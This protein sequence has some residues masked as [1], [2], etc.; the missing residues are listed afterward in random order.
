MSSTRPVTKRSPSSSKQPMSPVKYQPAWS[1]FAS[2]SGRRQYPENDSSDSSAAMISPS[3]FA[4][5][6]SSGSAAPIRTTRMR[7]LMPAL[8]AEPGLAGASG[9]TVKV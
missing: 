9:Q 7:W 1:D 3:S 2:A 6:V 5:M 4:G 8:P